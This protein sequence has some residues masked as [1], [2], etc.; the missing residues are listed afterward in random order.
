MEDH[1][2]VVVDSRLDSCSVAVDKR[3]SFAAMVVNNF[4]TKDNWKKEEVR[5]WSIA[6][7]LYVKSPVSIASFAK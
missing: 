2:P 6:S 1:S 4:D 5:S 3:D 7:Y